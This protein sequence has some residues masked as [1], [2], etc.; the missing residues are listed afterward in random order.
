MVRDIIRP[1]N[2]S[3]LIANRC[4]Y[5]CKFCFMVA[6]RKSVNF[7]QA[8]RILEN[9]AESG[10][11]KVS[12]AGGEPLLWK[13]IDQLIIKAKEFGLMTMLI[14]NG[15]LLSY[16][17]VDRL[18]NCLDWL[19]LPLEGPCEEIN[20]LMTRPPGHFQKVLEILGY[21]SAK[22]KI[23]TKINTVVGKL[24]VSSVPEIINIVRDY[25][26]SRWKILQFYPIRYRAKRF[27]KTFEIENNLFE[28]LKSYLKPKLEELDIS[29]SVET[30]TELQRSYL[31]ISPDG[32]AYI[33]DKANDIYLGDLKQIS[34]RKIWQDPLIDKVSYEKRNRWL[35]KIIK[36]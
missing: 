31:T 30:K 32:F 13:N 29:F 6:N 8:I 14:T 5:Q 33:S 21:C 15:S 26:V 11:K 17:R 22:K 28:Q 19:N 12:F 18:E 3:W 35:Q 34:L 1:I 2:V 20:V 10:V 24:N 36:G 25:R 16:E 27:K 7:S 9:L 4:N 23:N